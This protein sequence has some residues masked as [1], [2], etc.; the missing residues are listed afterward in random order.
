M[1]ESVTQN[2]ALANTFKVSYGLTVSKSG[3]RIPQLKFYDGSF[4][5]PVY[6]QPDDIFNLSFDILDEQEYHFKSML[7]MKFMETDF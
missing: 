7:Q 6:M 1:G 3:I 2:F 4:N 5:T